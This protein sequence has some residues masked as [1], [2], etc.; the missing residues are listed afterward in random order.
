VAI[1]AR[2]D[3]IETN[4]RDEMEGLR[5]GRKRIEEDLKEPKIGADEGE[6]D[7]VKNDDGKFRIATMATDSEETNKR[8]FGNAAGG[9]DCNLSCVATREEGVEK[10]V[11]AMGHVGK[12][13]DWI[14]S[15]EEMAD[16]NW[17]SSEDDEWYGDQYVDPRKMTEEEKAALIKKIRERP[18]EYYD[19]LDRLIGGPFRENPDDN[20][21]HVVEKEEE[22]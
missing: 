6:S 2:M 20:C 11:L 13:P 1:A 10:S 14:G 12:D 7:K 17:E 9:V 19:N 18:Q 3:A 15:D 22:D 8:L 21:F 16:T 5:S 4:R